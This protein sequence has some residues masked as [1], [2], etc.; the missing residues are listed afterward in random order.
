MA[1]IPMTRFW[2]RT[3]THVNFNDVNNIEAGYNVL[4]L[5]VKLSEVQFFRLRA[6][7]HTLSLFYLQTEILH[8]YA[9]KN[10]TAVEINPKSMWGFIHIKKTV[11][12]LKFK[13]VQS[14][15]L[16]M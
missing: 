3:L 7:V 14:F 12:L 13:E 11:Y 10:Y 2:L 6:T 8:R 1:V 4:R 15:E 16:G 5:K 9:P